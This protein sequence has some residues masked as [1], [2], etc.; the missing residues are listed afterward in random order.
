MGGDPITHDELETLALRSEAPDLWGD[1]LDEEVKRE[2]KD[3]RG[4]HIEH[5]RTLAG[6]G[7]V[8]GEE[9]EREAGSGTAEPLSA[10]N[11]NAADFRGH[12]R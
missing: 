10:G 9:E 4:S 3:V 5:Y 11:R 2:V 6:H 8:V 1:T 7:P 12:V